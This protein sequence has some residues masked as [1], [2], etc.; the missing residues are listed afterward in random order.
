MRNINVH[1]EQLSIDGPVDAEAVRAAV[2]RALPAVLPRPPVAVEVTRE[3][4]RAVRA[5]G[6]DH[7]HR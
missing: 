6:G 3:V 4:T 7:G 2:E 1:I 5:G